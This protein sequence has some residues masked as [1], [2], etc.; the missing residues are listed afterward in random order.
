MRS[1]AKTENYCTSQNEYVGEVGKKR[2]NNNEPDVR[3]TGMNYCVRLGKHR[4][5]HSQAANVFMF[6]WYV[7]AGSFV[8]CFERACVCT[9][10]IYLKLTPYGWQI[11]RVAAYHAYHTYMICQTFYAE[12][13]DH[14]TFLLTR[15]EGIKFNS[16]CVWWKKA[17]GKYAVTIFCDRQTRIMVSIKWCLRVCV[18]K[19]L[20]MDAA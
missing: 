18:A 16:N 1:K 14:R 12:A 19:I 5:R 17:Y 15:H 11:R 3:K 20:R 10:N 4:A 13:T 2:I 9:T 8:L 6:V 7:S